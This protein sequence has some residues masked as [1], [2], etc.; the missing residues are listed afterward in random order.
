MSDATLW[1]RAD[2]ERLARFLET[3]NAPDLADALFAIEGARSEVVEAGKGLLDRWGEALRGTI[4]PGADGRTK[5]EAM[6]RLVGR[7]LGFRGDA[8]DYKLIESS[9]LSHVI[10]RRRGLPILLSA[11]WML[12]GRR[13]GVQVEGVGM[14]MHFIARVSGE[15]VD[16]FGGGPILSV[17][18]CQAKLRQLSAGTMAWKD[19]MLDAVTPAQLHERVLRNLVRAYEQAHEAVGAYKTLRFLAALR[20]DEADHPL[21]AGLLAEAM[22]EQRLAGESY[23]E[24]L[25]RHPT[26]RAARVAKE[27]LEK[28][29]QPPAKPN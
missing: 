13:A 6:R 2:E 1:T 18:D 17:E 28:R 10:E 12:I 15:L 14:P 24:V 8:E 5:A 9:H 4:P 19:E 23:G 11:V 21:A 27:R 25:W 3:A 29:S 26:T 22:G 20:P 7:E 16:P